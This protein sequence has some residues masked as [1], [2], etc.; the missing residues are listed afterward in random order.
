MSILDFFRKKK[1]VPMPWAK[2][3]TDDE[4]NLKIPNISLYEQVRRSS[5][6]YPERWAIEY[7][8]MHITYKKFIKLYY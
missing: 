6:R 2:Y 1:P 4:L 8:G 5:L 3:Y 7:L